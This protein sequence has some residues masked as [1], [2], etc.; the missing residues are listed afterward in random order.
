MKIYVQQINQN[1]KMQGI[2]ESRMKRIK[3]LHGFNPFQN[4]LNP[5]I[6][7]IRVSKKENMLSMMVRFGLW[8]VR[9]SILYILLTNLFYNI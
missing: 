4:P 5:L 1:K 3:R 6:R 9:I 8:V 7:L 2:S